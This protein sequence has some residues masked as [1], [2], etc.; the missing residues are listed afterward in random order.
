MEQILLMGNIQS[1][2]ILALFKSFWILINKH[3]R[4]ADDGKLL[5]NVHVIIHWNTNFTRNNSNKTTTNNT[6]LI[7][8]CIL[9]PAYFENI[10]KFI[11]KYDSLISMYRLIHFKCDFVFFY[12][13]T[14]CFNDVWYFK[15][16][17]TVI[18]NSAYKLILKKYT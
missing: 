16:L 11:V 17:E 7:L 1:I 13:L 5:S 15:Q 8:K 2:I 14:L 12:D 4:E 3:I 9:L 10:Y 18:I 6:N